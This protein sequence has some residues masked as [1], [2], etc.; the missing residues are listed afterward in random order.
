MLLKVSNLGMPNSNSLG[1]EKQNHKEQSQKQNHK[2][3]SQRDQSQKDE[4]QITKIFILQKL[5]K[6][7]NDKQKETFQVVV[8]C[9]K[10]QQ[11]IDDKL[12]YLVKLGDAIKKVVNLLHSEQNDLTNRMKRLEQVEQQC[13]IEFVKVRDKIEQER[14]SIITKIAEIVQMVQ[15]LKTYQSHLDTALTK[16]KQIIHHHINALKDNLKSF[17]SQLIDAVVKTNQLTRTKPHDVKSP[18]KNEK[19]IKTKQKTL[20]KNNKSKIYK[21]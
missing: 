21:K 20:S 7:M 9:D 14:N 19:S 6:D 3:Q 4:D 1:E 13:D 2:D 12:T 8:N 15:M 5:W 10:V 16:T 18:E 11:Q 17:P